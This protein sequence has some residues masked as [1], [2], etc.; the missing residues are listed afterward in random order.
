VAQAEHVNRRRLH[1]IEKP[2]FVEARPPAI[3]GAGGLGAVVDVVLCASGG[4]AEWG[5]C[6]CVI[7]GTSACAIGAVGAA[8][9]AHWRSATHIVPGVDV[10]LLLCEVCDRSSVVALHRA[11]QQSKPLRVRLSN[12][13]LQQELLNL[14]ETIRRLT[15]KP[16]HHHGKPLPRDGLL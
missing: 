12:W 2:P 3:G 14:G 5:F 10:S 9:W 11:M 8:A 6:A 13:R 4:M 16:R 15:L 1:V 7:S